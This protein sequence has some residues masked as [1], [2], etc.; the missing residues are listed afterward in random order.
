MGKVG[1]RMSVT[2]GATGPG[3]AGRDV[4]SRWLLVEG[5]MEK[6]GSAYSCEL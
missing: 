5:A 4:G 1:W 3:S 2:N 6:H